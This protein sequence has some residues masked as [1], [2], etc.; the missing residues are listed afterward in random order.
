MQSPTDPC[1][2]WMIAQLK[3]NGLKTAIRNLERQD[4]SIFTP[5]LKI[6][7]RQRDRL[8]SRNEPLFPGYVF[9]RE[10]TQSEAFSRISYT[11]GIR[12]LLLRADRRPATLPADFVS[13]LRSRCDPSG[14]LLPDTALAPGARVRVMQGPFA[15]TV[16]Q[17]ES[18]DRDGRISILIAVLGQQVRVRVDPG[19]VSQE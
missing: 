2:G 17:I 3:P 14:F 18:L 19:H 15:D 9:V 10:T 13:S 8:V 7:R 6:T 12:R 16:S 5:M 4:F 11:L 1:D